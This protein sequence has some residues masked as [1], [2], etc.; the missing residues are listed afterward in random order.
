LLVANAEG[1]P[2]DAPVEAKAGEVWAYDPGAFD[3]ET[4]PAGQTVKVHGHDALLVPV[5]SKERAKQLPQAGSFATPPARAADPAPSGAAPAYVD[6]SLEAAVVW[7]DPSGL[8]ITVSR[9]RSR[10]ILLALAEAVRVTDPRPPAGPVGLSWL[11]PGL[12]VTHAE[13]VERF[14]GMYSE[15]ELTVPEQGTNAVAPPSQGQ[16]ATTVKIHT[17]AHAWTNDWADGIKLPAPTLTVAGHGGWYFHG[18]TAGFT[19]GPSEGRLLI[20]TGSC[21]IRVEV[22]DDSVVTSYELLKMMSLATYGS[23]ADKTGWAPAVS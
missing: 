2:P 16:G 10:E 17:V 7:R 13:T 9:T 12:A 22:A 14:P 11:P 8:W 5:L 15:I 19:F 3:P 1:T 21:G 23:C 6:W 4:L 18:E 20:D